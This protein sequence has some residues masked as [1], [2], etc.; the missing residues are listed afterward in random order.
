MHRDLKPDNVFIDSNGE[1]KLGQSQLLILFFVLWMLAGRGLL[2][3]NRHMHV[4]ACMY[5][6]AYM[7]TCHRMQAAAESSHS[8]DFGLAANFRGG[9]A[10]SDA[11]AAGAVEREGG[12]GAGDAQELTHGV[13]TTL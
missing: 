9:G 13:G 6:H 12:D 7:Y 1:I 8:G 10:S 5:I 2:L 11:S 4:I 3:H